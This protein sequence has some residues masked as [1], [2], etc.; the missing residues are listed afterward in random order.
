VAD[1]EGRTRRD[2]LYTEVAAQYG[3]ALER[4]ARGYEGDPDKRRDLL[5]EIH[6]VLWRSFE[7]FDGRCSLR[8][9]VYRVAHNAATSL[10]LRRR[11]RTPTLIGLDEVAEMK[12]EVDVEES[13]NRQHALARLMELIRTLRPVERQV[14]LLYLE[15]VDADT[16]ADVVGLSPSN[17]ATRVHRVKQILVR[18]FYEREP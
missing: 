4:L 18:Q 10:V 13:A 7:R 15:G 5:Q 9:W 14:M 16:I 2:D 6:I 8:T 11:T 1:F 3:S 12:A 17:V